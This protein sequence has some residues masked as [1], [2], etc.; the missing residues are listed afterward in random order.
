[1]TTLLFFLCLCMSTVSLKSH[2]SYRG[3]ITKAF[4]MEGEVFEEQ[5]LC[6]WFT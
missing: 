4:V 1:M 5:V 6:L 3:K 2:P